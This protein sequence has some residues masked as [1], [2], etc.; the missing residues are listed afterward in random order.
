MHANSTVGSARKGVGL[1]N[2]INIGQRVQ[3]LMPVMS[4]YLSESF[5]DMQHR[6]TRNEQIFI[7]VSRIFRLGKRG[8]RPS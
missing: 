2:H 5:K 7:G 3:A 4:D 1:D 6:K 8:G